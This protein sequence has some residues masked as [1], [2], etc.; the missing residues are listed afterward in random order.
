MDRGG[1][2]V[3]GAS[4]GIG[5][6]CALTLHAR[7]YTVFAGV[8]RAADGESLEKQAASPRLRPVILDV[9][10]ADTIAAAAHEVSEAL[11]ERPLHGLVNNAGV[12][13]GGPLEYLAIDELRWQLEVNVVGQLAVTKAFLPRLRASKGRIVHIGSI[14]GRISSPFMGPYCASKFALEALSFSLREELRPWGVQSTVVEPGAVASDIWDKADATTALAE[15]N[16]P[17]EALTR[18]RWGLDAM[19]RFVL[20]QR[21][22]AIPAEEVAGIVA[23][24][25]EATQMKARYLAGKEAKMAAFLRWLVSDATL[26]RL[27][28]KD[29][30]LD[31]AG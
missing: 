1:V 8:R 2:V 4:T 3:T 21:R 5:R 11:G 25:L 19:K 20:R 14:G 26:E 23:T 29:M 27:L 6:A 24:A 18:Y 28:R 31:R 7:G 12:A 17:P 9:T 13:V 30:G 10:K 16:L 22:R 15:A